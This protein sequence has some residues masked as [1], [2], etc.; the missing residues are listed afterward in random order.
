M[1]DAD[2]VVQLD[3]TLSVTVVPQ[4]NNLALFVR[5]V[6]ELH[7]GVDDATTLAEA[8]DVEERTVHYYLDFG[9]WLKLIHVGPNGLTPTGLAFAESVPARGRIFAQAMF[10]RKLVKTVQA[11]KRDSK[12]ED[13]LETLDTRA[14]CLKAIKGLTDL[15]DSTAAR[16]ASGVAHMLEAAYKPSR[17]DWSTGE[18]S[19]EHHRKLEYTGRSFATAL[20][21]RQ[22]GAAREIRIG[23]PRQVRMFVEHEGH[24]I[25]A[26]VWT[27]ASWNTS[28][29][30][31]VWFGG[32]PI[33]AS[34]V[35]VA[36]RGGRDLRRFLV[37]VVPYVSLTVALL[38]YRD[39]A[40][41]PSTRLT[42]DMYG[43][44]VWEHNR[45]VGTPLDVVERLAQELEIVPT[46]AVPKELRHADSAL[47]EPGDDADLLE[48]LCGA[49]FIVPRDTTYVVN[50]GI[51]AELREAKGDT[52]SLAELLRPAWSAL[53]TLLRDKR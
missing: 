51:D 35:E 44:R 46:K 4:A 34:T 25:S 36:T 52:A 48:V 37:Q 9:R 49:G 17:F 32:V 16:R 29:G 3:L 53:A 8:L 20:G 31:A 50:A 14:A 43:L 40:G 47:L 41:R 7:R 23:F 2:D 28:D 5:L 10:A 45:E 12:N 33:N 6:D 21:A 13:D 30:G 15:S 38:T 18:S 42:H 39:R 22:F 19:G 27:R 11:L 26:K 1:S 24:G